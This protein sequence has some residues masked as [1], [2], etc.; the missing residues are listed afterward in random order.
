M[1]LVIVESPAKAKTINKYL[2][3]NYQVLSSVGHI[4]DLAP[5]GLSLDANL[6]PIYEVMED[7]KK[8]V[9][10]IRKALA[11][12]NQV[13]LM[14]DADREGE[15][16]SWHLRE[17]LGLKPGQYKRCVFTEITQSAIQKAIQNCRDIDM[18][19]VEAQ[20]ARRVLD[21]IIGY[22]VSPIM[23]GLYQAPSTGR[24]QTVATMLVVDRQIEINKFQRKP[25]YD[26][27]LIFNNKGANWSAK[28]ELDNLIRSGKFDKEIIQLN[29]STKYRLVNP[30]F[31]YAIEKVMFNTQ[32]VVV[33]SVSK[34]PR[35]RNP[36]PPFTTSSLLQTASAKLGWGSDKIMQVAQKLYESGIITYMRTDCPNLADENIELVRAEILALQKNNPDSL[37]KSLLPST[38]NRFAAS[39]NA[40]EGHEAIRP[41]KMNFTASRI[42]DDDGAALYDLIWRRTMA[43]QMAPMEY[44]LNEIELRS[45]KAIKG[46]HLYFKASGKSVTFDGFML[47]YDD[48]EDSEDKAALPVVEKNSEIV[49]NRVENDNKFT[50]PPP[51]YTEPTLIKELEKREIARPSTYASTVSTIIKRGYVVRDK[52]NLEA[53]RTAMKYIE[54]IR[55]DFTFVDYSYTASSE[56]KLDK[57][58]QGQLSFD[59]FINA[60][61][62]TL[63]EDIDR[64]SQNHSQKMST[65]RNCGNNTLIR[66]KGQD[67]STHYHSCFKCMATYPDLNGKPHYDY[68]PPKL[69]EHKC[70]RCKV[71]NLKLYSKKP[72]KEQRWFGCSDS[73]CKTLIP[74]TS[75]TWNSNQP[76]PDIELWQSKHQYQCP[77]CHKQGKNNFLVLAARNPD[78]DYR[79][80]FCEL[81]EKC[82]TFVRCTEDSWNTDNPKPDYKHYDLNHTHQCPACKRS[83]L[84]LNKAKTKWYCGLGK[85]KCSTFINNLQDENLENKPDIEGFLRELSE[86]ITCPKCQK[87]Y[88]VYGKE[89]GNY[90][91]SA[92]CGVSVFACDTQPPTP[93][94]DEYKQRQPCCVSGC[95]GQIVRTRDRKKYRCNSKNCDAMYDKASDG[96]PDIEGFKANKLCPN[97]NKGVLIHS[98]QNHNFFCSTKCGA[99]IN[100]SS[101]NPELPDIAEFKSRPRCVVDGCN[102]HLVLTRNG[103]QF[104]CSERG[105]GTFLPIVPGGSTPDYAKFESDK[106]ALRACPECE[107][108]SLKISKGSP[109]K[110]PQYFC[111]S[112]ICQSKQFTTF[113]PMAH[114]GEPDY[115]SYAQKKRDWQERN[116]K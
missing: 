101:S 4:R 74:S 60:E 55:N 103:D 46:E 40:Q 41:T 47:V 106:A 97:C 48:S 7:K 45:L 85:D 116:S 70:P 28:L 75:D 95:K 96:T 24:V 99:F 69:T 90:F 15:A 80:Y 8:V 21:R 23:S 13:Y 72:D 38:P 2:G 26:I 113:V 83:H 104:R 14:T 67:K 68:E 37:K 84:K 35:T 43:C 61:N 12:A 29:D 107:C 1:D 27:N 76:V 73:N 18:S 66:R 30:S 91:C 39:E 53:T 71:N 5:N 52:K 87:G 32:K 49:I 108:V 25:Y 112:N 11:R 20:E 16:I 34:T 77:K 6:H 88:L 114:D 86:R 17:E 50:R 54:N 102:G 65:C 31:A 92:K 93:D 105:C 82:F 9:A 94:L 115:E 22:T 79:N 44:D 111:T 100:E 51:H 56:H 42:K 59:Q 19:M 81:K 78:K 3:D 89:Y 110:K 64:F 10:N 109:D 63:N 36:P 62:S 58:H 33:S 98:K 57:I